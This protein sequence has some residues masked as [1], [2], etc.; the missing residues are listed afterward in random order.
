MN[1]ERSSNKICMKKN[2]KATRGIRALWSFQWAAAGCAARPPRHDF[3]PPPQEGWG[4]S[5]QHNVA[6][7]LP[8]TYR[9]FRPKVPSGFCC[10]GRI[11]HSLH[12]SSIWRLLFMVCFFHLTRKLQVSRDLACLVYTNRD[13][14]SHSVNPEVHGKSHCCSQ[15]SQ[16]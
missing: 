9:R 12:L 6:H 5:R 11:G 16:F 4:T 13:H 1:I 14:L 7:L 15:S 3:S 10:G 2:L 8:R